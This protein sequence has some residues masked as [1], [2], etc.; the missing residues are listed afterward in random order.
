MWWW[1]RRRKLQVVVGWLKS[2]L[3]EKVQMVVESPEEVTD[4]CGVVGNGDVVGRVGDGSVGARVENRGV[5]A[6]VLCNSHS[7]YRPSPAHCLVE[8]GIIFHVS[9]TDDNLTAA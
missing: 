3:P 4:G 9:D 6:N 1:D 5:V 8:A 7:C 2:G